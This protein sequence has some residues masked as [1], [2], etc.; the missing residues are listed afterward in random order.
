V[1][2]QLAY[3]SEGIFE[4]IGR[5]RTL[6]DVASG[7]FANLCRQFDDDT[8]SEL[9]NRL[10]AVDFNRL[11]HGLKSAQSLLAGVD[12]AQRTQALLMKND[13]TAL[14][15]LYE[16]L[17]C[18]DYHKSEESL[19]RYFNYVF[20]QV[21][22]R[23]I[24]RIGD[25]LP[26]MAH[27]L[28]SSDPIRL[29]FAK[30]AWEKMKLE[31][32]PKSFEWVVHDVLSEAIASV[33]QP[34]ATS[35]DIQRFWQGFLLMLE[36]MDQNL[37]THSL[38]G[39]EVQPNI[40]FLALQ[41]ITNS[42]EKVVQLVIDTLCLLLKKAP[43]DFWSALGTV[44]AAAVAELIFQSPGY[45][46]ILENEDNFES[47][48][49]SPA[50]AWIPEFIESQ[51]PVHQHDACRSLLHNLFH[52]LQIKRFPEKAR[53]TCCHAGLDA[54]HVTLQ[55]F[56]RPEY[57]INPST[58]LIVIND[59]IGLVD[60]YK[61]TIIGCTDLQERGENDSELKRAAMLVLQDVL[62][63]DCKAISAEFYA[64]ENGTPVQRA[65]RTHSQ[66]IWQAVLDIFRP[67]N[68]ELAKSILSA[69]SALTGL[70]ELRPE[71]K[72]NIPP[73]PKDHTQ[74][75]RDFQELMDNVSRVFER[76]SDFS[77]SDLQQL[78]QH[79]QT[80]RPLFAALVS[81]H[82]GTYE[83]TVELVKA[84]TGESGKLD[85]ISS[86]L[87]QA[88][89]PML[90]S[91][92][93]A[94][95]R[96]RSA[97]NFGPIPNMIK[98][99][100]EILNAL[101]GNTG[102]L[103]TRSGLSTP[104][105]NA[106]MGW[107]TGQW[108]I[109]DMVFSTLEAWSPRV[110]ESTA[111]MQDFCRDGMEY[112]EA[113]FD[114]YTIVASALR[115]PGPSDDD[116]ASVTSGSSKASLRKVLDIVCQ[117]VNGLTMLLR[118][119]DSYLI[120]VITSLLGKLLRSL[121]EYHLEVDDYASKYIKDACK[122]ENEGG[123]KRT[124]LT[125][126]QKAELQRALDEH[127]GVE[128]IEIAR[129]STTIKKQA[130][131]DSWSRSADGKRHEPSLP[132]KSHALVSS[133]DRQ[134][135]VLDKMR[136]QSA[137]TDQSRNDFREARRKAA[138]ERK[139]QNADAIAKAKALRGPAGVR[140]EGSGLKDIGGVAG[141]DHTPVRSEIMVG[142]SDEDSGDDDDEDETNALVK[143]RKETSKKVS[144]Y[145][146]SRRRALKQ[147]QQG[148]VKK[149]K[150]Q[151]SAKDLRA[152]VEPNM[153]ALYL[154]ILNWDLFHQG[155]DPPSTIECRKI[156][157]E[158]YDLGLYKQTFAPLLISEVWRS[159]VTARDENVLKPLEITILNRLSVDKFMEVSTKMPMTMNRDL[160]F[161]ERDIVLLS[162]SK[163]PMGN[164]Q[165]PHC[166]ARVDRT[167]RKK[168]VIEVTFR[169]SRDTNREFVPCLVPQGKI[170]AVKIAD[171][172]TTQREYAALSSLE[173]YDLCPEVLE[174]K[175]SPLQNYSDDKMNLMASKYNLNRGQA[176]AILSAN[177][178]DGFT[179][180]Q[181]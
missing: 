160:K 142:S 159:L 78:Y 38:R 165:D 33:S 136:A 155:D 162:R 175:P 93:F 171:M 97:K 179:L 28:F 69:T 84:M 148:P 16:A 54:L 129:P 140:G 73:L 52:S 7:E 79:P 10:N 134:R 105:Q 41:H 174:A 81:A 71:N 133:A 11:D 139:R 90:N 32:A 127:Q 77:S 1:C 40:Y 99:G 86:L 151:R 70:D 58:S 55:T 24:L 176:Q 120:G 169:I 128:V 8:V 62:A 14:L 107:W 56:I 143:T 150:V 51:P 44:S 74:F 82:Q 48:G 76:L 178:N 115:D 36:R 72:K 25:I 172:T 3:G 12:Q 30:H 177:D 110:K 21:Q 61:V 114:E 87:D 125:N 49:K 91:L 181:G 132:G 135:A 156:A 164:Q 138:E 180:I 20:E 57:Q 95:A 108:R 19:S 34:S 96:I 161:N 75:N 112:A 92:T 23:K 63:L 101:C 68:I 130:T 29:R 153:D 6:E 4:G 166:L 104:E 111:F 89:I 39:M 45:G 88:F 26:A 59:I 124:N 144:E 46:K 42:S 67:G 102:V 123:F 147:M 163:D 146:E 122:R 65:L 17:C 116:K 2:S 109:L 83:A 43:K 47:F 103:R 15:A 60:H 154:E 113:L 137:M 145:E 80:A 66:S 5:V 168:D 98:T 121:G 94:I 157:D 53:L 50:T 117:N 27:F 22:T 141:K 170:Y 126:Q 18:T 106:I 149:I 100:G 13:T 119:R 9:S 158:F 152:R 118:L 37:V 131:I 85:A 173:Y 35:P 167:N 31:L 64:L